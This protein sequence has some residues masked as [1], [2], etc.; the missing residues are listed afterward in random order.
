MIAQLSNFYP[1]MNA[2]HGSLKEDLNRLRSSNPEQPDT[3]TFPSTFPNDS[4]MFTIC[5]I[6]S[7]FHNNK[8]PE[9]L[10]PDLSLYDPFTQFDYFVQQG[11]LEYS[12]YCMVCPRMILELG[13]EIIRDAS[14]FAH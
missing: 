1:L 12:V 11:Q 9:D 6:L 3:A 10:M 2:Y 4:K 8:L 5:D 13:L 14:S 7:T